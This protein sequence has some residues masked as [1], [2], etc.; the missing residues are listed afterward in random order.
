MQHRRDDFLQYERYFLHELASNVAAIMVFGIVLAPEAERPTRYLQCK[1][2]RQ[3]RQPVT[4][5]DP[6][7]AFQGKQAQ[8]WRG[9]MKRGGRCLNRRTE[10][11][12]FRFPR[13]FTFLTCV[14]SSASFYSLRALTQSG[15]LEFD[16]SRVIF[17]SKVKF[18]DIFLR[19]FLT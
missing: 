14:H 3:W 11:L 9:R 2:R 17:S 19:Q 4:G 15:V 13:I 7:S 10:R 8:Q 5:F 1:E 12:D 16:S 18:G 6:A